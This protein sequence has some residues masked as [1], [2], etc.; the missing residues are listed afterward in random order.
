MALPQ[1]FVL[2]QDQNIPV[3]TLPA[4]F[5]LESGIGQVSDVPPQQ[6]APQQP[7]MVSE[8]GRQLGLTAKPLIRGL[9]FLP[10]AV[11]DAG[12][13][14]ANLFQMAIGSDARAPYLSQLQQEALD[15]TFGKPK[16]GLESAVQTGAEAVAGMMTPGMRLPMAAPTE[17]ATARSVGTRAGAEAAGTAAGA[18]TGEQVAKLTEESGFNP[19]VSLAAGL[20]TGTIVGSGTAQTGFSLAS[21]RQT[22]VTADQIRQRATQG[23]QAMDDSGVALRSESIQKNLVP[24]IKNSLAKEDYDP[25]IVTAHKPIQEN[26]KLLDKIVADPLVD[27][28]RLEKVRSTFSGL[29]KGTDDTAR[30]AKAVTAEIDAFMGNLKSK[31]TL[32]LSG[33][34]AKEAFKSLENARKDW[35]NQSRAQVL[36]DILESASAVSEGKGGAVSDILRNKMV[37]LTSN[38]EKMKMFSTSEQNVIKAAAKA[39]DLEGFLNIFAKFNPQRGLAQ[40][41][42]MT[43][44]LT[45]SAVATGPAQLTGFGLTGMGS[46]G[47]LADKTLAS[48][49]QREM[50]N[51]IGQIASGNLQ[52]P[53]QGF[54]V[55]GLFGATLGVTP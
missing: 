30:L 23:Y 52:P 5:Q 43:T 53:K 3:N 39:T 11:V 32:T 50:K 48:M 37:N 1:G 9:S 42:M 47:Y 6:T 14:G 46:A 55:P 44:G 2:E 40:A 8:L 17:G 27:F 29:S 4:G 18:I 31:D 49:R 13:A 51:L 54:A 10:N 35:R 24:S 36:Q 20:A 26:L 41:S 21:P 16:P 19:W 12:T 33:G 28:G 22:P 7:S 34:S 45:S 38:T 25:E 15:K